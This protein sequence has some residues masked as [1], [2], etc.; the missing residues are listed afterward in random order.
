M[1]TKRRKIEN[2]RKAPRH[3]WKGSAA[4]WWSAP[5]FHKRLLKAHRGEG[6]LRDLSG[7]GLSLLTDQRLAPRQLITITVPLSQ[8]S[9]RIPTLAYVQWSRPLRGTGRYAAGVSFVV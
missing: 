7:G 2:R 5:Y 8:P 6:E 9:L 3:P 1:Q 4:Y